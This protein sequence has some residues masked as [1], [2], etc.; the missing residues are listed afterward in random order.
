MAEACI[1]YD[2][3][4]LP[5]ATRADSAAIGVSRRILLSA[6]PFTG[7]S[8][9][10]TLPLEAA[11]SPRP[12]IHTGRAA[13]TPRRNRRAAQFNWRGRHRRR[14]AGLPAYRRSRPESN[15]LFLN[16]YR[17]RR[18]AISCDMTAADFDRMVYSLMVAR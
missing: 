9:A 8:A 12:I 14:A 7:L 18:A 17:K 1:R 10:T 13:L 6:F 16:T 5:N 4:P 11:F 3:I 2:G 15:T